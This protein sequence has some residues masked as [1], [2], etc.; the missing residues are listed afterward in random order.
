MIVVMYL[1]LKQLPERKNVTQKG[2][3]K[4]RKQPRYDLCFSHGNWNALDRLKNNK[5][6]L[7]FNLIP[8]DKNAH[9]KRNDTTPEYYLQC[10]PSKSKAVNFSGIRFLYA[11]N[12][13]T[14]FASGEPSPLPQLTGNVANP[15]YEQRNDGFLFIFSD[16]MDI[17]EILIIDNGR[18]L[19]D[20]YRKQ[21]AVGHFN[22]I[23]EK[24]R[25]QQNQSK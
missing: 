1:C 23:L 3:T 17:L 20:I 9:R 11:E 16:N 21:L 25:E 19:I 14:A 8:S 13:R 24:L 5:G 6:E 7:F 22:E 4:P 18:S 12:C 15:M 2:V 10:T